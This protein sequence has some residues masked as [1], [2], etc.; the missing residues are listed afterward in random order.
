[1]ATPS[2]YGDFTQ[3]TRRPAANV[4]AYGRDI[5]PVRELAGGRP[6]VSLVDL[7]FILQMRCYLADVASGGI[8]LVSDDGLRRLWH[9]RLYGVARLLWSDN[10]IYVVDEA[11]RNSSYNVMGWC[12]LP[13]PRALSRIS[14]SGVASVVEE[15]F[16]ELRMDRAEFALN[17]S[18]VADDWE[19]RARL[20]VDL[21]RMFYHDFQLLVHFV[22]NRNYLSAYM[23][24]HCSSADHVGD[25]SDDL[26]G[27]DTLSLFSY[28]CRA[29]TWT[30]TESFGRSTATGG[31]YGMSVSGWFPAYLPERPS[32]ARAYVTLNVYGSGAGDW[33]SNNIGTASHFM[34]VSARLDGDTVVVDSG[35][36][37]EA[38]RTL[39]GSSGFVFHSGDANEHSSRTSESF[40]VSVSSLI[41]VWRTI[42]SYAIPED[43]TYERQEA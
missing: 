31:T 27:R 2:A 20:D 5:L 25:R 4:G 12:R 29:R 11:D 8:T 36:L 19:A 21:V 1:M 33:S 43:W 30:Q 38:A 41:V 42:P 17:A 15:L 7:L 9:Y 3:V 24:G 22:S 35:E 18:T 13:A 40:S 26:S 28:Y 37:F 10:P 16:D 6:A 39:V 14:G 23:S 34:S 32:V